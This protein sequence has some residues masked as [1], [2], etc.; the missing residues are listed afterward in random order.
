M[1]RLQITETQ[2][3][4]LLNVD[5]AVIYL[6]ISRSKFYLLIADNKINRIKIGS[7]TLFD[8]RDLD[9]F[10]ENLKKVC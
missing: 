7:R 5:E 8:I 4:R 1:H 6:S 3:K 2:L 10:I 9:A